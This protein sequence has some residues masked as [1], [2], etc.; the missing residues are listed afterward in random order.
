[1]N[2]NI[3]NPFVLNSLTFNSGGGAFFLGGNSFTFTTGSSESITQSSSSAENIASAISAT[4]NST[5]TLTLGGNGTGVVTMSGAISAGSGSRDYAV[6]GTASAILAGSGTITKN[7][8]GTVTLSR[9]NTM[10]GAVNRERRHID[11]GGELGQRARVCERHYGK[12]QRN[13]AVRREQ[14]KSTTPPR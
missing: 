7:T 2:Q 6:V 12:F 1:L 5:V 8:S 11:D 3:A 14:P 4:D 10:S 9:A 13:A